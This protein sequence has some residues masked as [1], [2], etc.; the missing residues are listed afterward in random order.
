LKNW[1]SFLSGLIKDTKNYRGYWLPGRISSSDDL[2]KEEAS[3]AMDIFLN[4]VIQKYMN[5]GINIVR[6]TR[7]THQ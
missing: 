3:E 4:P 1:Q 6:R 5:K 2:L 7:V